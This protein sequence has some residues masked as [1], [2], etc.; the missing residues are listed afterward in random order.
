M[1][2]SSNRVP[3]PF[4]LC[5]GTS[6]CAPRHDIF[7]L[8]DAHDKPG[9]RCAGKRMLHS[10]GLGGV[11]GDVDEVIFGRD[12]DRSR[13]AVKD[14]RQSAAYA[15]AKGLTSREIMRKA[16]PLDVADRPAGAHR[17]EQLCEVDSVVFG[18]DHDFSSARPR[19]DMREL[20]VYE[21]ASGMTSKELQARLNHEML[22]LQNRPA[23]AARREQLCEVDSVVFCRDHDGSSKLPPIDMRRAPGYAG[24]HGLTSKEV[25][26]PRLRRNPGIFNRA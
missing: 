2:A 16:V 3:L 13:M 17:P 24:A 22:A 25:Q 20:A 5:Q 15:A 1:P 23:G 14:V 6:T 21:D 8:Q 11:A 7:L 10:A 4:W 12:Q 18:R 19:K 9:D 26:L